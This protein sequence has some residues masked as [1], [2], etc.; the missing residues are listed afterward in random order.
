MRFL[1]PSAFL[2]A[3]LGIPILVL[4]MLKLRRREVEISST[5]LW[6]M[7]LR[8]RQANSPWQRIKRNLL[9]LLQLLILS[10][11]VFAL[12]RP[13]L[14]VP[15]IAAGSLVVVLDASASM[16]ATDVHPSRFAAGQAV[17]RGLIDQLSSG[18]MMTVI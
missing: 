1:S 14:A 4:Y 8:D 5:L 6:Q 3:L 9:L 12:A 2:F 10:A 18:D 15:S 13:A 17:V 7:L 16:N 11:V